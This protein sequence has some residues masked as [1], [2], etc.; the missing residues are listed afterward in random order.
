MGLGGIRLSS[1]GGGEG[2]IGLAVGGGGG[3][4]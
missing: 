1:G 4:G 3:E 2:M